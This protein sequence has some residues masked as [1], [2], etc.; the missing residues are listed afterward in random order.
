MSLAKACLHY[1]LGA[2][3][4]LTEIPPK[5][6]T[7]P[8]I[9]LASFYNLLTEGKDIYGVASTQQVFVGRFAGHMS[10]FLGVALIR[11]L[12]RRDIPNR[13]SQMGETDGVF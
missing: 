5:Q 9:Q 1:N 11:K 2:P 13:H 10:C 4:H 8:F 7:Q 12:S 6:R 3:N